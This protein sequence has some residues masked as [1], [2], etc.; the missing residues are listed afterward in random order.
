M[1][2]VAPSVVHGKMTIG[3]RCRRGAG[4]A[5][6]TLANHF[7]GRRPKPLVKQDIAR[8]MPIRFQPS[9]RR[10]GIALTAALLLHLALLALRLAPPQ[11]ARTAARVPLRVNMARA[12]QAPVRLTPSVP[13]HAA[14][15]LPGRVAPVPRR[16]LLALPKSDAAAA[17]AALP[18]VVPEPE[19]QR[20]RSRAEQEEI[21]EF[22]NPQPAP[23][24]RQLSGRELASRALAMAR[25]LPPADPDPT[26]MQQQLQQNANLARVEPFS[27]EMYFDALYRKLNRMAPMAGRPPGERGRHAAAV[28]VMLKPDGS[29]QSFRVL[30]AADQQ[31]EIAYVSHLFEIAAP[32]APFPVDIRNATQSLILQI[33]IMPGSGSGDALFSPMANGR[34]CNG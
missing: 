3:W 1:P 27:L 6:C 10:F 28:R 4:R 30:W 13:Q 32:F 5:S 34:T 29:V 17:S 22:L 15:P 8:P 23:R 21:D 24:P 25:S 31:A 20:T 7:A 9:D 19:P 18:V 14:R 26:E 33:C 16:H 12:P 11:A 2:P